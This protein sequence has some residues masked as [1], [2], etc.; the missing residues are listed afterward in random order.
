M[1]GVDH[2]NNIEQALIDN[3]RL[4]TFSTITAGSKTTATAWSSSDVTVYGQFPTTEE[5]KYPAIITEMVANGIETQFMGQSLT[6]NAGT[7][8]I[9]ELYGVGFNIYVM[10]DRDSSITITNST[11][12]GSVAQP[13]KERR[14]LNYLMLNCAN[15]LMDYD[16]ADIT[17]G[18]AGTP[19][20]TEI[21]Q[22]QFSG[23]RDMVWNPDLELW[24][25]SA[26]MVIIF[27]NSR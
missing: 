6:N 18:V 8:S 11:S 13:Y 19:A 10:V 20:A 7:A 23:F 22:R 25:A 2:L 5:V 17:K 14:L 16:F 12:T 1:V 21:D 3:L 15:I 9:G 27:K 24:R 4:G 26:G